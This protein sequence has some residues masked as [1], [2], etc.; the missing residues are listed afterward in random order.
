MIAE[1]L[2]PEATQVDPQESVQQ[3]ETSCAPEGR[4]IETETTPQDP[5]VRLK[6]LVSPSSIIRGS[7]ANMPF[8]DK[9]DQ[10]LSNHHLP[11]ADNAGITT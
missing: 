10:C 8:G 11:S 2:E 1:E 4:E 3:E 9:Q 6:D 5:V 7:S